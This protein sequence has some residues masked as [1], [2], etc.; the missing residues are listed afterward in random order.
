MIRLPVDGPP[1]HQKRSEA[2]QITGR[3][4]RN[5]ASWEVDLHVSAARSPCEESEI[6]LLAERMVQA[7][8]SLFLNVLQPPQVREG[9]LHVAGENQ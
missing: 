4:V 6:P 9:A 1:E 5:E 2:N 8:G 3:V 7:V